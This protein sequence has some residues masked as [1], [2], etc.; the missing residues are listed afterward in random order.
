MIWLVRPAE[1]PDVAANTTTPPATAIGPSPS[2]G[3]A[4]CAGVPP[5]I[6]TVQRVAL[7]GGVMP[8]L[9][10]APVDPGA[11]AGGAA[12]VVQY[13]LPASTAMAWGEL[14]WLASTVGVP[15]VS[16]AETIDPFPW[17]PQLPMA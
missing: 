10:A 1:E 7:G 14:W 15:P 17:G 12:Y 3:P 13:T 5:V 16:G 11:F 6:G 2:S 9:P 8:P 4:S